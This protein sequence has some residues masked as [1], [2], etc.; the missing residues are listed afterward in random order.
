MM[1]PLPR[2]RMIGSAAWVTQR[3]PKRLVSIWSR[4]CA[5]LSSSTAPKSP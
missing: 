3:A 1:W 4:A 2:S 5:S